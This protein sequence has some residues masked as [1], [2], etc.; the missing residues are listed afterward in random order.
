MW[1]MMIMGERW[2][3]KCNEKK[4]VFQVS[5]ETESKCG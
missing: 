3:S 5:P 2:W 4:D 1:M